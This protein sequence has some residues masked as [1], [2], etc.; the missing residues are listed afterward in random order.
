MDPSWPRG[1]PPNGGGTPAAGNVGTGTVAIATTGAAPIP[2]SLRDPALAALPVEWTRS[3]GWSDVAAAFQVLGIDA[4]PGPELRLLPSL[5]ASAG[6]VALMMAFGFFGKRRRDGEPP[7]ADE[8]LEARA[9]RAGST[10]ASASLVATG[11]GAATLPGPADD[12]AAMPR[13]RRPS[14]LL[15]RKADPL[16]DA[17]PVANLTFARGIV[18]PAEG[19]ERRLIR[20]HAVELLDGP[21]ELRSAR[22]GTLTQGDEVQPVERSGSYWLVLCPDGQQGWIHRMTLGD[23][24]DQN[25]GERAA[26]SGGRDVDADV[27]A[28]FIAGRT[29][30]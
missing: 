9:R 16:R 7:E 27:L 24:V 10:S 5:V 20:Y 4:T 26:D 28:A 3:S 17:T 14:L 19:R 22:V 8:L 21:D 6:G 12:E 30:A 29:R 18:P 15:A 13:W 25:A 1:G 23:V 2:R 11:A